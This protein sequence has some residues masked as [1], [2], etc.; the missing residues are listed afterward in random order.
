MFIQNQRSV[1]T[2]SALLSMAAFLFGATP[3]MAEDS[4]AG[5]DWTYGASIYMWGPSMNIDTPTPPGLTVE[6]PFYQILNDLKMTLMGEVSMRNDKWSFTADVIYMKLKQKNIHDPQFPV[7]NLVDL[8]SS[9]QMKSW[10]L[11][12]TAGYAIHNSEKARVE[13]FGGLRYLW[14]DLGVQ[15]SANENTVFDQSSSEGFWDGIV[16][17]RAKVNL[18]DKWFLPMSIDV[19][20]GNS[21]GT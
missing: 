17:M 7:G 4:T 2:S 12:P 21:D 9:V 13:V 18:N 15:I 3:V 10:I 1:L 6:L 20:G 8:S 5:S 19:G 16:G 11:S 14:I